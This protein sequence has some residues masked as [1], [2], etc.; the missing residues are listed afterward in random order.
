MFRLTHNEEEE[1]KAELRWK[2]LVYFLRQRHAE[3]RLLH[4][5]SQHEYDRWRRTIV[6]I[7]SSSFSSCLSWH[8]PMEIPELSSNP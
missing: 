3:R 6:T 8:L 2:I 5:S 7:S 4:T 1:D